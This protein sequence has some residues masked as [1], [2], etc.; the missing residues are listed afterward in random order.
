ME[1]MKDNKAKKN[2]ANKNRGGRKRPYSSLINLSAAGVIILGVLIFANA[3]ASI[4]YLNILSIAQEL[5]VALVFLL[6]GFRA[7][8]DNRKTFVYAS[9]GV[10][11]LA[12]AFAIFRIYSLIAS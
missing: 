3:N 2:S 4:I 6:L 11:A 9:F 7:K 1:N 12:F 10:A 8:E 5:L